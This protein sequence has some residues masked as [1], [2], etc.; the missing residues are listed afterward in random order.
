MTK[1]KEPT[2]SLSK[3]IAQATGLKPSSINVLLN[4]GRQLGPYGLAGLQNHKDMQNL[5]IRIINQINS[6]LKKE[7]LSKKLS[8]MFHS[9]DDSKTTEPER[10]KAGGNLAH[11]IICAHIAALAEGHSENENDDE[12]KG[13]EP[14]ELDPSDYNLPPKRDKTPQ[15]TKAEGKNPDNKSDDN[16]TEN[17]DAESEDS[18]LEDEI[19]EALKVLKRFK[20][21][22]PQFEK[23]LR[24]VNQVEETIQNNLYKK[25][26]K[27]NAN[28]ENMISLIKKIITDLKLEN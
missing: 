23:E 1:I 15:G 24:S 7:N 17:D 8:E 25:L 2:A 28:S 10:I 9:L 11:Q 6:K 13:F 12:G 5:S 16:E 27:F 20:Y 14:F 22:V 3:F 18:N 4:F 21:L 19:K 26:I